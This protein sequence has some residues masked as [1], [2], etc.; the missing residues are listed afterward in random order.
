MVRTVG[1]S[2]GVIWGAFGVF[3]LLSFCHTPWAVASQVNLSWNANTE[4]DLAGY[5][6]RY[7]T[8]SRSYTTKINVGKTTQYTVTGLSPGKTYYFAT[9]AYDTSGNESGYSNEARYTVPTTVDSDGDGLSDADERNIYGTDPLKADTDG[10]GYRDGAEV[11]FWGRFWHEDDDGD[12]VINL[13]DRD[14]DGDGLRD[15]YDSTPGSGIVLP[16]AK[17]INAG[18]GAYTTQAGIAYEG[19]KL[20]TDSSTYTTT[21][22]IAGTP[23]DPLFRN[24]RYGNFSYRIPLAN[25]T[26]LVTL[27]FAEI[28]WSSA[29]KRVFDVEI[30]GKLVIDNLDIYTKVGKNRAYTRAFRTTVTDRQLDIVFKSVVDHAKV[31]AIQIAVTP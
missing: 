16:I 24:E 23:D 28:Y 13:L 3:S 6:I 2:A 20:F 31:N 19:D 1:R 29:G 26:Y 14:S 7:G 22:A 5:N 4:S 25:D 11:A 27:Q 12:G 30:D 9:T 10:D 17:A 8:S 18:G 15:G 21:A